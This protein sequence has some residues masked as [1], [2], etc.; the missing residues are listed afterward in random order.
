MLR[1]SRLTP[2]GAIEGRPL[3][4]C[5]LGNLETQTLTGS[6]RSIEFSSPN[7]S[8]CASSAMA[9][10]THR[11]REEVLVILR[12][13]N[14]AADAIYV[15]TLERVVLHDW[16]HWTQIRGPK[17]LIAAVALAEFATAI[18]LGPHIYCRRRKDWESGIPITLLAHEIAHSVQYR[19]DG[20]TRFLSRYVGEYLLSRL[21]GLNH[22]DAY[23]SISYEKEAREVEELARCH[24]L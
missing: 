20:W 5:R 23:R 8:P 4:S 15:G 1:R 22:G 17:T 19:R 10:L 3:G 18:T 24:T 12:S 2:Q 7:R 6:C 9:A 14:I 16:S 11:E 13:A 21:K